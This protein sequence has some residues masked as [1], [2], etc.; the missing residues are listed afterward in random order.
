MEEEGEGHA[1]SAGREQDAWRSLV[2]LEYDLADPACP[3]ARLAQAAAIVT[4]ALARD[5]EKEAAEKEQQ[6]EEQAGAP[7]FPDGLP[8]CLTARILLRFLQR[9]HDAMGPAQVLG[10]LHQLQ[11]ERSGRAS[12]GGER[13]RALPTL[14]PFFFPPPFPTREGVSRLTPTP[15]F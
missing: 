12:Q 9:S 10:I 13:A 11:R 6:A 15:S 5:K 1:P 4:A 8:G 2:R 3:D 14:P 7:A